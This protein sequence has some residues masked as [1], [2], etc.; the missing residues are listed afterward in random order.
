MAIDND[1][2]AIIESLASPSGYATVRLRIKLHPKQ[3]QVLD[4]LFE[5]KKVVFRC[6]NGVG[7]TSVV[8]VCAILYALEMLNAQ[9]VS[10]SA[11]Y[12]Q[13]VAQLI[14]CLKKYSA[15]YPQWQF[16]D[17]TIV[18]G[19]VKKYIGFSAGPD[20]ASFQGFHEY[21][22]QPLLML[23]DEAAGVGSNIFE[24]IDR[25]QPTY[26]LCCGSPLSPEGVFYQMESDPKVYK[27]FRHYKLNQY[28]CLKEN[29]Y[30]IDRLSIEQMI[31]KWGGAEHPLV[32]S[33]VFGEFAENIEGSIISLSALE[34]C[35]SN[36]PVYMPGPR[37][38]GI[39]FGGGVA[40]T[41][42]Y[43]RIGNKVTRE[44]SFVL[45]DT[46]ETVGRIVKV[47]KRLR[48]E[49]GLLD[50]EINADSDGIGLPMIDRLSENGFKINKFHGGSP[51]VN[52]EEYRNLIAEAW[53]NACR[54][55]EKCELIIDAND[56]ELRMQLLSRKAK[57]NSSGKLQLEAKVDMA[58]RNVASP[59]RA[60]S[61]VM[62]V[63]GPI[64]SGEITWAQSKPM[65]PILTHNN[66][67]FTNRRYSLI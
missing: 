45:S 18:I 27:F 66:N 35:L 41:A 14:P 36:P 15:L 7:K 34:K 43:L 19:G 40:E 33:S 47:L 5:H 21:P 44:D 22:G 59:D 12:R 32:K 42:I 2:Q 10:T 50:N 23:V 24:Q 56:I 31:A 64:P 55:I 54:K 51:A 8:M 37:C 3:A 9:V 30:W 1:K 61:F 28:E 67:N 25:C 38:C 60:D 6:G 52:S 11:T 4:A 62:A 58:A 49:V 63:N 26:Y 20:A 53:I 57:L 17:N 16:L 65:S 46:M 48:F 13:V 29:G 39:D